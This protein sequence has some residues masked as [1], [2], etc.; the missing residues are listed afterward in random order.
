MDSDPAQC[1]QVRSSTT[2]DVL[3]LREHG[4][5]E[6]VGDEKAP[7]TSRSMLCEAVMNTTSSL[8]LPTKLALRNLRVTPG[9]PYETA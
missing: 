1:S 8:V 2:E 7:H 6:L 4:V 3:I 5:S 9:R